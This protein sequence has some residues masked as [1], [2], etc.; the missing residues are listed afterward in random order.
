V[1]R[2]SQ[3]WMNE[4]APTFLT[5]GHPPLAGEACFRIS[6]GID[7]NKRLLLTAHELANGQLHFKDYPVIQLR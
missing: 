3:F 2:R 1:K 5:P 4:T 7:G 6:F